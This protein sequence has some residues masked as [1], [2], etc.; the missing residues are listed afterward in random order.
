MV[1]AFGHGGGDPSAGFVSAY[2][3]RQQFIVGRAR[4]AD[5]SVN[6]QTDGVF[7]KFFGGCRPADPPGV[8]PAGMFGDGPPFVGGASR[9]KLSH[10]ARERA[11]VL[12][13]EILTPFGGALPGELTGLRVRQAFLLR[14]GE[15]FLLHEQPCLS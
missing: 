13:I 15:R 7:P 5:V 1:Q 8:F 12:G 2:A 9:K 11:H 6:R 4:V 10:T 3:T 14:A